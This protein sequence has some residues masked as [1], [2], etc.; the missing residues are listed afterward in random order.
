VGRLVGGRVGERVGGLV[1]GVGGVGGAGAPVAGAEVGIRTG[2]SVGPGVPPEMVG[3]GVL[4]LEVITTGLRV[5]FII[6]LQRTL[7]LL[8]AFPPFP[9][10]DLLGIPIPIPFPP[11]LE[12][13][14]P[15]LLIVPFLL[16]DPFLLFDELLPFPFPLLCIKIFF[17]RFRSL[18]LCCVCRSAIEANAS[19]MVSAPFVSAALWSPAVAEDEEGSDKGGIL[20]AYPPSDN[21]NDDVDDETSAPPAASFMICARR[22]SGEAQ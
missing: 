1:G 2:G 7:L 15:P 8:D 12:T 5:G 10:L 16:I 14:Q 6:G 13:T 4:G 22:R 21:G 9:F 3:F 11:D 17:C 20:S 19:C 18:L